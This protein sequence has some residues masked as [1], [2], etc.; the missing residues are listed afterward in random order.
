MPRSGF[1]G[2]YLWYN[3]SL[4]QVG[5]VVKRML[6]YQLSI[7]KLPV[8]FPRDVG[9]TPVF[10]NYLKGSRPLDPGSVLDNGNLNFGHQVRFST[11]I[12]SNDRIKGSLQYVLN[13]PIPLWSFGH[14][15]S[16]TT[17]N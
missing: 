12:M 14:G 5:P 7:G 15:L 17:F 6:I 9:T 11:L 3:Q 2:S 16:Y 4:R 13:S 1:S 10:Y 8:S